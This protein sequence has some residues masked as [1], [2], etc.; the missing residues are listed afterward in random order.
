[1]AGDE[2]AGADVPVFEARRLTRTFR[3]SGTGGR[4]IARALD[5][6]DLRIE[7]GERADDGPDRRPDGGSDEQ[8]V[9]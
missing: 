4:V 1:M 5:G 6:V 8:E 3:R 9:D 2:R 7:P